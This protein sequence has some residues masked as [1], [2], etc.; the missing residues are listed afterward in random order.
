MFGCQSLKNDGFPS[1]MAQETSKLS[2]KLCFSLP[3]AQERI[4]SSHEN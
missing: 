1:P 2:Q 3:M 4:I